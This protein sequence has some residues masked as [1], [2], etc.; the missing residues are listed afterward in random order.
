MLRKT[1][2]TNL[3]RISDINL[4]PLMDLTLILLITFI[5]TFPLIEQGIPINLP[6]GKSDELTPDKARTIT[7]N[8]EGRTFLNDLE[9]S[10]DE[11]QDH[12]SRL[13]AIDPSVVVMV[14]ADEHLEYGRV[15]D[16]LKLLHKA[17]VS[18]MALVTQG[19]T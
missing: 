4:T 3:K 5:I 13:V 18:K 9:L 19:E 8:Q 17:K 7:I 11:L 14:R 2:L 1:P 16:V 10:L 15:V 12:L 6:Q